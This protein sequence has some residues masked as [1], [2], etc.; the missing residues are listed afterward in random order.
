MQRWIAGA[1][2]LLP[3]LGTWKGRC[4]YTFSASTQLRVDLRQKQH[5]LNFHTICTNIKVRCRS[6]PGDGRPPARGLA[7][8]ITALGLP[9]WGDALPSRCL[10]SLPENQDLTSWSPQIPAY[11]LKPCPREINSDTYT[12][13][14]IECFTALCA[15]V[16][17]FTALRT[18]F[19][20][21]YIHSIT[22]LEVFL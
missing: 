2:C 3:G 16:K 21:I 13:Y 7:P 20:I 6:R 17:H 9:G 5:K 18:Y 22:F 4:P 12:V 8:A 11:F 10:T 15:T 1:S 19:F 14:Q